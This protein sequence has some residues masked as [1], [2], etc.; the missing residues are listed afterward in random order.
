MILCITAQMRD[1][2]PYAAI[3]S[4]QANSTC[5]SLHALPFK[6]ALANIAPVLYGAVAHSDDRI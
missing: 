6:A 4:Q 3:D 1:S 2:M 5:A